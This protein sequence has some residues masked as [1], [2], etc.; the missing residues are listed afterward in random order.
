MHSMTAYEGS[1]PVPDGSGVPQAPRLQRLPEPENGP[2]VADRLIAIVDDDPGIAMFNGVALRQAGY[3]T[4]IHSN[5]GDCLA[6]FRADPSAVS[7]ILTDQSMPGMTGMELA[8]TLRQEG[9]DVPVVIVSGYN[10]TPLPET[11]GRLGRVEFLA[12]PYKVG[13]LFGTIERM[14]RAED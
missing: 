1:M 8:L 6:A 7:L 10:R 11:M 12:K 2:G 3:R 13:A 14:L 4:V 9:L 5:A